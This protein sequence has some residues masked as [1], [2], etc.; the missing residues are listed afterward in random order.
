MTDFD[1][2]GPYEELRELRR[3]VTRRDWPAIAGLF[4]R[5]DDP[6]DHEFA[7]RLVADVADS[8]G[9]FGEAA[10]REPGTLARTLYGTRLISAGWDVRTGARATDVSRSQFAAFH[11]YL[12]RAERV[13][14]DITAEEPAN[15][16]AWVAR[17]KVN[18]GLELGQ[19]EARRRY[20]RLS[21]FVPHLY[22][23]QAN[24]V[25]QFC[26]KWGGSVEKVRAF[27]VECMRSGPDG[28]LASLALVEAH[29]EIAF[30]V[31]HGERAG[32]WQRPDVRAE[33]EEAANRSVRHPAFRAGY[34]ALTAHNLFALAFNQLGDHAA[35][36]HHFMAI[37]N[38]G[39]GFFWGYLGDE[40]AVFEAA[41]AK[42]MSA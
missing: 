3:A 42:A 25:Q 18:R 39:S 11:D 26:K 14:I 7:A 41:R 36:R 12:R 32:Y 37:G 13:L 29:L 33:I 30:E 17:I 20:D 19:N 38:H 2:A 22:I 15:S 4:E 28:S 10:Q 5:L 34:R 27:G 40:Q 31:G 9:F 6:N 21:R 24:L 35:A 1:P 23:A 8:E 16:T